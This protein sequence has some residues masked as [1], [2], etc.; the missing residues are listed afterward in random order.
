[1]SDEY[2]MSPNSVL[3]LLLQNNDAAENKGSTP[4]EKF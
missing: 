4:T 2:L 3:V 1:M